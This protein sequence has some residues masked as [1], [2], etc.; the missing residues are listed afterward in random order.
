MKSYSLAVL[1]ALALLAPLSPAVAAPASDPTPIGQDGMIAPLTPE[2]LTAEEQAFVRS[3]NLAGENLTRYLYTRAYLRFCQQV[4]QGTRAP[5]DLPP[6]P[7]R[8]NYDRGYLSPE[9]GRDIVDVAIGR[10]LTARLGGGA[11]RAS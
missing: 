9:E 2:Q 3:R 7:L 11:S 4:I 8:R 10:K 1:V 5:L 6:L